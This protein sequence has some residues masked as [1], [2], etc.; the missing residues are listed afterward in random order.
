MRA[1]ILKPYAL[2]VAALAAA[3]AFNHYFA[4]SLI[5]LSHVGTEGHLAPT[6]IALAVVGAAILLSSW[7]AKKGSVPVYALLLIFGIALSGFIEPLEGTVVEI[8]VVLASAVLMKAGLETNL[9]DFKVV[10]GQILVLSFG[11]LFITA[12]LFSGTLMMIGPWFGTPIPAAGANLIGAA[13]AS[14]DPAAI[15]P[16]LGALAWLSAHASRVRTI[17]VSESAG[18]DVAGA[19][20]VAALIPVALSGMMTNLWSS[21]YANL[22]TADSGMFLLKQLGGGLMGG[23]VGFGLLWGFQQL[24][25]TGDSEAEADRKDVLGFFVAMFASF[26]V[27]SM[28]SGNVFLA[29]FLAGLFLNVEEH[30]KHAHHAYDE[31]IDEYAIPFIFVLGGLL[32]DVDALMQYAAVGIV[33][34]LILIFGIRYLAVAIGFLPFLAIKVGGQP[35]NTWADVKFLSTVRQVGAIG[36]VLAGNIASKNIPGTE[37]VVPITAWVAI[38]TLIVCTV[39]VG[40]SAIK[41]G[42]AK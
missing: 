26:A 9:G 1:V 13:I 21:G 23:L 24:R 39:R 4:E 15:V 2:I 8:L 7:F 25:N 17:A 40:P 20:L 31:N 29:T 6:A 3:V 36:I 42:L 41:N 22:F 18:T 38:V 27:A 33:S 5:H 12:V 16:T 10:G 19:L 28:L 37:A 14:T 34:S 30:L 11:S 35:M 32:V